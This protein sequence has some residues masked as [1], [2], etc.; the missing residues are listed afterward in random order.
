MK[1]TMKSNQSLLQ[2]RGIGAGHPVQIFV[3]QSAINRMRKYTPQDSGIMASSAQVASGG[4]Q[5][6]QYTPYAKRQYYTAGYH[7]SGTQTHHWFDAMKKNGGAAAILREA[8]LL[9]GAMQ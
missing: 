6:H 1:L 5:I 3:A 9:A 4:E 2:A 8:V 7:H